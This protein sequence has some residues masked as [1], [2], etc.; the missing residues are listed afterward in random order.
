MLEEAGAVHLENAATVIE[1]DGDT[2]HLM[3]ITDPDTFDAEESKRVV[4]E[5]LAEVQATDGYDILLFHRA[6]ML[7]LF[8][9]LGF[10]LILSGHNHGGQIRLPLLGGIMTPQGEYFSKYNEGMYQLDEA[11]TAV[12]SRGIGNTVR[13]PRVNNPPELVVVT[14]K[15]DA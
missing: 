3:G 8:D 5:Y 2:I 13:I 6:N 7:D 1:K 15:R 14:L 11:T 10:E 12:I 4:T 9:G